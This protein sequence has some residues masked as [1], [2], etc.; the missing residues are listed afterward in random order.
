[1]LKTLHIIDSLGSGGKERR[2]VQLIKGLKKNGKI[3]SEI[4]ILND[5]IHYKIIHELDIKL[6][7]LKRRINKD[8]SIYF[9]I[10]NIC[11]KFRPDII[12]SWGSMPSIYCAPVSKILRIKFLNGQISDAPKTISWKIKI[13][14]LLTFPFSDVIVA[15]SLAGLKAYNIPRKKSHVIYN[16]IDL[17]RMIILQNE[18]TIRK[19]YKIETNFIIGIVANLTKNKDHFTFI[20]AAEKILQTRNDITFLIVGDYKLNE[21]RFSIYSKCIGLLNN[22]TNEYIKFLG[23]QENVE[24]LINIFDIGILTTNLDIHGEGIS[25][26]IMEYMVLEKPVI[27]TDGGGTRELVIQGKTGILIPQK[28]PEILAGEIE[29]LLADREL[30]NKMGL[31]GKRRIENEFSLEKMVNAYVD[32]SNS[33]LN[34]C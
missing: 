4:I 19:K 6:H 1:V 22:S 24:S 27:A 21:E 18:L 20:K 13:R 15:N 23:K 25:N 10:I 7:V 26:S 16:G 3:K 17:E 14:T 2:L 8:P 31:A 12:H 11:K 28:S 34:N 30:M 9:K 29:L 32:L 33:I 5:I